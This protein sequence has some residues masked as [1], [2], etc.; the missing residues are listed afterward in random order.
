MAILLL[1]TFPL[2]SNQKPVWAVCA[3]QAFA[4]GS[5]AAMAAETQSG[6]VT[7]CCI[8]KTPKKNLWLVGHKVGWQ[9][10]CCRWGF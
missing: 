5:V 2:L 6:F 8:H 10:M 9:G 1:S 7:P 4:L 3:H